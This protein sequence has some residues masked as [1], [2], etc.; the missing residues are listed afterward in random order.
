MEPNRP[1]LVLKIGDK[2]VNLA[3]IRYV[4][5]LLPTTKQE[6]IVIRLGEAEPDTLSFTGQD[7]IN[8]RTWLNSVSNDLSHLHLHVEG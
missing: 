2:F 7:A 4:H 3:A 1:P 5:D 8:L 6:R